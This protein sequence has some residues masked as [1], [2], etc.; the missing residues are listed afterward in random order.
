MVQVVL[1]LLVNAVQVT[2]G[3]TPID[4]EVVPEGDGVRLR[5]RDRGPGIPDD[6]MP[7]IFDP[8]FS[9]KRPDENSGLGLSLSF[10]LVRQHGGRLE[11]RNC[12][13]GGACFE[14]WLPALQ[15]Q[16]EPPEADS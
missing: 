15:D 16:P 12:A 13:D 6:V 14:F 10:D 7:H 9:T 2:D 8:F 11:A 1:N 4:L 3:E 5:V